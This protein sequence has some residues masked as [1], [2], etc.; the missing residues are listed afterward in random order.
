MSEATGSAKIMVVDDER[1]IV[2]LVSFTLSRRGYSVIEATDGKAA[3][4]VAA[5]EQ[6][7]LILMDVMMPVMDGFEASRQLKADPRTE[8]IPIVMLSAKSQQVERAIGLESGALDYICKPF[9][10]K[11]LVE[12]VNGFLNAMSGK[13][14]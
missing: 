3:L 12:Q 14:S 2:R 4:E 7:D 11:E 6:P 8:K 1:D 5:R 10:P 9:T 13:G